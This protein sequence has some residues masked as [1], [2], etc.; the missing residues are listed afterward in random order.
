MSP[1]ISFAAAAVL[2][3]CS[4]SVF[5]ADKSVLFRNGSDVLGTGI[6]V[7][8]SDRIAISRPDEL[9]EVPP[10]GCFSVRTEDGS[11][12][13][14]TYN[15]ETREITNLFDVNTLLDSGD[16]MRVQL[17][18][19]INKDVVVVSGLL[20]DF[21]TQA[22]VI[23][24]LTDDGQ[25]DGA[26]RILIESGDPLP[27]GAAFSFAEPVSLGVSGF[28]FRNDVAGL[29]YYQYENDTIT[30]I[31]DSNTLIP[32]T[33]INIS[34]FSEPSAG[35]FNIGFQVSGLG[36][37]TRI[38]GFSYDDL[39][40]D[41]VAVVP[42]S[43]PFLTT[44][45]GADAYSWREPG[46]DF[47]GEIWQ[48]ARGVTDTVAT[49]GISLDDSADEVSFILSHDF[50]HISSFAFR[51]P[52]SEGVCEGY[53]A[54]LVSDPTNQ[55]HLVR[56]CQTGP[57]TVTTELLLSPG[58]VI[59]GSTV[60]SWFLSPEAAVEGAI[61]VT[62]NFADGGRGVILIEDETA[63][64]SD[65]DGVGDDGDNCIA[66]ANANQRDTDGDN[67]GNACDA[68]LNNDCVVNFID[69]GLLRAVFFTD[70]AN[71]DFDGDGVVNFIDL[72]QLRSQFFGAPGPSGLAN[73]CSGR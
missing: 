72:G 33:N 19:D 5:A 68:D 46:D 1:R 11:N 28:G 62:A 13:L 16:V 44:P 63:T 49:A 15:F 3:G 6:I 55:A 53:Q 17:S 9:V 71:A 60:A 24:D 29:Y 65:G 12:P 20:G 23:Q 61:V 66:A 26:P 22:Y 42:G 37:S 32:G 54:T 52:T 21:V 38:L 73:A 58:E 50:S 57:D 8:V 35:E 45:N 39:T 18:C 30:T 14:I 41:E 31:A 7:G 4:V 43:R 10:I 25:P 40:L 56:T 59:D 51:G 34:T 47:A 64:D 36:A 69:L 67:I 70:D 27:N 2:I 48:L